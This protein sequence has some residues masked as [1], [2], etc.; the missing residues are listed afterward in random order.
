LVQRECRACG[1][2]FE[3]VRK[4]ECSDDCRKVIHRSHARKAVAKS[5]ASARS[6]GLGVSPGELEERMAEAIAAQD[7]RKAALIAAEILG[8]RLARSARGAS[9]TGLA[10][11]SR[12]L[13][14]QMR[15]AIGDDEDDD[16]DAGEVVDPERERG[17]RKAL[18][19]G[20]SLEG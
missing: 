6:V 13:R 8:S 9:E 16:D 14:E 11:L 15:V 2:S 20:V 5:K 3:S 4:L 19:S 1:R 10:A 7:S 17:L 18:K 12:E